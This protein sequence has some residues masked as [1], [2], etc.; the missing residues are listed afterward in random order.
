DYTATSGT[1]TFAS[2]ETS[3]TITV[4]IIGDLLNEDNETFTVNLSNPTNATIAD[5]QGVG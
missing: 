2:G 5:G 4:P 3:K 1:L